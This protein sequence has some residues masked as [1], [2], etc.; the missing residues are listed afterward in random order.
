MS[1]GPCRTGRSDD[2]RH[3]VRALFEVLYH[4]VMQH[5]L[6]QLGSWLT[7]GQEIIFVFCAL[8]F[9]RGIVGWSR[10]M[11]PLAARPRRE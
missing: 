3:R 5:Y 11:S 7:V 9:R 4:M 2:F 10:D 6:A 1:S 8:L